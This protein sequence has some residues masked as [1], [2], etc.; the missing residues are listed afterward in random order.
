VVVPKGQAA[1]VKTTVTL[2]PDLTAPIAKGAVI[3]KVVA[4]AGS[5]SLGEAP[6]VA[7]A[8]VERAGFFQRII[9]RITG[10]FSK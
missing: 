4:T 2:N 9:Q 5:K 8:S 6:V 1:T 10:L 3:G 7:L